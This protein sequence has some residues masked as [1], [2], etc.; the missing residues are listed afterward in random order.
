MPED[1]QR[2]PITAPFEDGLGA[3]K[4]VVKFAGHAVN[5]ARPKAASCR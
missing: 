4:E 3:F 1:R 5:L 2:E